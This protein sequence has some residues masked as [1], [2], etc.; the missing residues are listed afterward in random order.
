MKKENLI[1]M[2]VIGGIILLSIGFY[3]GL[4]YTQRQMEKLQTK[5]SLSDLTSSRVISGLTTTASGE[6]T[7]I[8]NRN[9]TLYKDGSNLSIVITPGAL[10]YGVSYPGT[11][12]SETAQPL[13]RKEMKFS[14]IKVGDK[15]NVSCILKSDGTLEGT[16][17]TV[18]PLV[19]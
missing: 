17:V 12:T 7:A 3:S 11:T 14:E 9:L 5:S 16:S 18:F 15:V 19:K 10:I 4:I 13:E 2:G 6:V 8:G 1:L